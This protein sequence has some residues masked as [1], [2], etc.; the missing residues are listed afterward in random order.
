MLNYSW[1]GDPVSFQLKLNPTLRSAMLCVGLVFPR[2][3][4]DDSLQQEACKVASDHSP[5]CL[6]L[7]RGRQK[8][9][10]AQVRASV[11]LKFSGLQYLA[12]GS[13]FTWLLRGRFGVLTSF[14]VGV[15]IWHCWLHSCQFKIFSS[16]SFSE[17]LSWFSFTHLTAVCLP[18]LG[19][20]LLTPDGQG[21]VVKWEE[22]ELWIQAGL[23]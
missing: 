15:G 8:A 14:C 22:L 3:W 4:S 19:L 10:L 16:L 1:S 11:S 18:L 5:R 12:Q 9:Q 13:I 2:D 6:S 7:I 20:F 21:H 17:G 23:G